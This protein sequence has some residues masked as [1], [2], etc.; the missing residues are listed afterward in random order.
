MEERTISITNEPLTRFTNQFSVVGVGASAGG[1]EAFKKL[2]RAIPENSGMAYVLVQ[3][4]DPTHESMLPGLLQKMTLIPVVEIS[5][6]VKIL[7]N[8]IYIIP[9]NKM[10]VANNGLLAL[11]P[12]T[13]KKNE[14]NLPID[15]FFTSLAEAYQSHSIGIILSGTGSDGTAGLKAIKDQGGITFSQDE[16]SAEYEGMP[17]SAVLAGV[18]DFVLPPGEIPKKLLE[19]TNIVIG[20]GNV[21]QPL[22]LKDEEV[23]KKILSVLR[24]QKG[25]DFTH[26]KQTTIHRRILR[27]MALNKNE[28]PASYLKFLVENK[29]EQ[30]VLYQDLLIPVTS[31]FRDTSIFDNLCKAVL[32][33]ITEDK[34]SYEPIRI[35]VAGCSTGQETYSIA[36]CLKEFLGNTSQTQPG[37][38]GLSGELVQIFATDLSEPA[39]AKARQ[40]IYTKPELENV[41]PER[42]REF[43]TKKGDNY[44]LN[45][46][47]RDMCV[48]AHHDFLKDPPF[49]KMDL[50]SCRNVLIYM[51][52]Y[53]QK[54]ALTTF[55]YSLKP[56]RFLLLG[57]S[58]TVS[59]VPDLFSTAKIAKGKSYKLFARKDAPSRFMHA[60]SQRSELSLSVM[61]SHSEGET[62]PNDFQKMSD[63]IILSRYTPA[64]VVVNEVMDIVH[65]RGN[66]SSF[67]E[68]S[69]GKP[70][71]NLLQMAK[72]GLA[73]ELRNILH[74]AK[75]AKGAVTKE[76]IPIEI[77]GSLCIISLEGML[78][79]DT[80]E[81]YFLILFH[82]NNS[83]HNKLGNNVAEI[84]SKHSAKKEE[85]STRVLQLEQ[86]LA[87]AREDMRSITQEQEAANEELQTANEELLSGSEELQSLNEEL[88]SGKEELQ[89]TN[90]ELTVVN[91][92]MISLNEQI[93][94]ARD[95]AE[96]IIANINVP[97]LVLDKSLRIQTGNNAFYKS[98]RVSKSETEGLLIYDIGNRQWNIPR[99]KTA[100][101]KILPEKSKVSDF[102]ITHLFQNIGER[103]VLL[104][105]SELINK[106]NEEKLILLS[107][108]DITEKATARKKI[109]DTNKRYHNVLMQSPFA[110]SIMKGKEM[111]ITMANHLMKKF[112]GKGPDVEG[113]TL[114]QILPEIIDQPFQGLINSVYTTGEPAY[115]N[116]MLVILNHNDKMEERY[117]NII[118][119]PHFEADETLSGVITIAHEVTSLVLA[120]KKSKL[121]ADMITDL[122]MTA[123]GF[124]ATLS[125]P[126][127]VHELV[128]AQYQG[129]F[130]KRKIQGKP[131]MDALPELEGQGFD[132]LLDKVYNRG[133]PYVGINIPI[134]FARDENVAPE[135]RYFTFSCQPIYNENK[136]ISSILIFGYEL[137]DQVVAVNSIR[138]RE[139]RFRTLADDSPMFVF[140]MEPD[141]EAT[142]SYWNKT[143][144]QY[145]GQSFAEALGRAW[146]GIIHP[147]D[148]SL[149]MK[150]YVPAFENKQPYLIPAVRVLRNDGEYRWHSFK[151]NPRY[152][153][154]GS[155]NGYVGVGIDIHDQKIAVDALKEREE[156][157]SALAD[158]IT[159]LAWMADDK[160][161]IYWYNQRWYDYTGTTI[162]E[163]KGWG[164]QKIHHPD[165]IEGVVE[166][167]KKAIESGKDWE[168]TFL[169]RGKD[170]G[171]RWFLSRAIP[172]RDRDGNIL[173]WFGTNTDITERKEAEDILKESEKNFRQLANLMPGKVA[174]TDSLGNA[175]FFNKTWLDY[176]G[177]SME[178]LI[179]WEW[180]KLL[181]P[182]DLEKNKK[183]WQQ[184]IAEGTGLVTEE[185]LL[186]KDG[187]YR[188]HLNRVSPV[189]DERG[190]ITKWI[191]A[192]TEI[193][194]QKDQREVLEQA[195]RERTQ[196]LLEV[197]EELVQKNQ[198][199]AL[200]FYNKKFL[201]EFSERFAA[202]KFHDEFFNA[203]VTYVAELTHIDYVFVGRL[204]Q[205]SENVFNIQTIALSAFGK[206]ADNINYP[207]PDGPC[208][209]VISGTLY[210]YPQGCMITFPKNKTIAQ[211]SVEGYIGYPLYNAQ[212]KGIGLIAVMHRKK[213]EDPETVSSILKIVA[214]RAEMEME[215][216]KSEQGLVQNNKILEEKNV[217]LVKINKELES[218]TYVSSHDLQEPL[219][220]IQTFAGYVFENESKNL[221]DRG[222]DF[223]LRMQDAAR[224]MQN[225]IEDLLAFSR[226]NTTERKFESIDL[227]V[228]ID[229][230]KK[231][232]SETIDEKHALI[233]VSELCKAN[234]IVFQFHQLMT[235]LIGNALKFSKEGVPPHIVIKCCIEKG[236]KANKV[237]LSF[238]QNYC[239]ISVQDN[240]IGFQKEYSEKI[241]EVFQKLHSKKEYAG[242]GIGLAIVKKIV[243]HHNGFITVTSELGKGTQF[244][245]YIPA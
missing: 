79:P 136:E 58:E 224:R 241:F 227:N 33:G 104:N 217:E 6:D 52:P 11:S 18:V 2:L 220:K 171:Y 205:I 215:R 147:D 154:N 151:G 76:N 211:F 203:A 25:T 206:L 232:L 237:N 22:P 170:G 234:I 152:L 190:K 19:V 88:E 106:N 163:M 173:R 41:S 43:F 177:L 150:F 139:E 145:T 17:H 62:I 174:H 12:R 210:S 47:I 44:Q 36:I 118:Y 97:L 149:V 77:N 141:P 209:Q 142:I 208:E 89:S 13:K 63:D 4:L 200:S 238:E 113:K 225:L 91:Q 204:E 53:L 84:S 135:E 183:L 222:K 16:A 82:D 166:R 40:G 218:F 116:E 221:T 244:D 50:I 85:K 236:S 194:E 119:Q 125:G 199:I 148:V 72:H 161:G 56:K 178:E 78:L 98:F 60:A 94:A 192:T 202:Y 216:I 8:H 242:T 233:D 90:E 114:T 207:L 42:L 239:H 191:S 108:E 115:A 182:D 23:F 195:I 68:N 189:K 226:I 35:W 117:F 132:K 69:P 74:K 134:T 133:E 153:I 223:I 157:F 81:P 64:G 3:H 24:I 71:H 83:I 137:T 193:Q 168:D 45:K 186:N 138:E 86:E 38:V 188:W 5:A 127:H 156:Q 102:K 212:E 27:R 245:I 229:E 70:S 201:T 95:Y 181:H 131:I 55:H 143:W 14:R 172:I 110:F 1:L 26:Y 46:N 129:L 235:N 34:T 103:V 92:E 155:F 213:I 159:Q 228:I 144:L 176:T 59:G 93:S 180:L 32:P 61:D 130:G 80:V 165:M 107:I 101:E 87:Q 99:L 197:N 100:L 219:R 30:V 37:G 167:F 39:I 67:L 48:F 51:E 240:G 128:N 21:D 15:I 185:R 109:E 65:F 10:L 66:T 49:S 121:Q 112:W 73:F 231:E 198:D 126:E 123:P 124:I 162:E 196:E 164:W 75:T 20:A 9:S 230:V 122:L 54:R 175:I 169:L 7:P 111:E 158:N 160:G 105:A 29:P 57:K 243:E 28:D 31:F 179:G 146:D 120:R 140:I 214:K 184:S 187:E 96:A